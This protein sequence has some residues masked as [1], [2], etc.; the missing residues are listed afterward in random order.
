M[1]KSPNLLKKL[2]N[3]GLISLC[4]EFLNAKDSRLLIPALKLCQN[5]LTVTG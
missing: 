4:R 5:I 1:T 2:I 3:L